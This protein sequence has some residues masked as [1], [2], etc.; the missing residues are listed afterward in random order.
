MCADWK[1]DH[2]LPID[3]NPL[4]FVQFSPQLLLYYNWPHKMKNQQIL[5]RCLPL[6]LPFSRHKYTNS[7]LSLAKNIQRSLAGKCVWLDANRVHFDR[8]DDLVKRKTEGKREKGRVTP[9]QSG[10]TN[11]DS[12]FIEWKIKLNLFNS[13]FHYYWLKLTG[14]GWMTLEISISFAYG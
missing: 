3:S 8:C 6:N 13:K 7:N 5:L 11:C 10:K 12:I 14:I 9:E 2:M 4:F 1:W